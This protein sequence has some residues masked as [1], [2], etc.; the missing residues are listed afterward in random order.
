MPLSTTEQYSK[1]K[2]HTDSDPPKQLYI[3][4]IQE[5]AWNLGVYVFP[6]ITVNWR[7]VVEEY[8]NVLKCT[9]L[10]LLFLITMH[11]CVSLR[12]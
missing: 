11:L 3:R 12:D 10:Q 4:N 8:Q 9:L 1:N 2:V 5:T 6:F 7:T